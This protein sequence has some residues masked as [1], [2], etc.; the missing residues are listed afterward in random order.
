MKTKKA[1]ESPFQCK[2]HKNRYQSQN[3]KTKKRGL[4]GGFRKK[5][6][7]DNENVLKPKWFFP[8]TVRRFFYLWQFIYKNG[9]N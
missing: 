8:Q 5:K 2:A 3:N 9:C 7:I 4:V 1:N 6:Q